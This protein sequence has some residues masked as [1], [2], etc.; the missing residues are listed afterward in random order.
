MESIIDP[1]REACWVRCVLLLR[2]GF[3][4]PVVLRRPFAR[5]DQIVMNPWRRRLQE[6]CGLWYML[7]FR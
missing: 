4:L 5:P 6:V 7:S 2:E 1:D 3:R